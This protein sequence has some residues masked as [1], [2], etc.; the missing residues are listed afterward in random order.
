MSTRLERL[1]I[2][3][4]QS[5]SLIMKSVV[6]G[7]S[8]IGVAASYVRV[9]REFDRAISAIELAELEANEKGPNHVS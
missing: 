1:T 2:A 4:I 9:A 3:L 7:E 5:G 6:C 8:D